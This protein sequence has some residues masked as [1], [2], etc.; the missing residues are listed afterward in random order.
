MDDEQLKRRAAALGPLMRAAGAVARAAL[1]SA[2]GLEL[3]DKGVADFVTA[4]DLAVQAQLY[5]ELAARFPEDAFF[6]EEGDE[7]AVDPARPTWVI[8]PID[9]TSNFAHGRP[10]WCVSAALV[11]GGRS[12]LAAVY[13]PLQDEL[14]EARRGGGA[15]LGERRLTCRRHDRIAGAQLVFGLTRKAPP[16]ATLAAVE[17]L[18]LEGGSFR[19]FGVGALM[20][21]YV[22]AGRIDGFFEAAIYAWDAAAA[23]LVAE[24]A[25]AV[26]SPR[27]RSAFDR[28][29]FP[30]LVA[31]P[32]LYPRLAA[33]LPFIAPERDVG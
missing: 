6:G 5:R 7:P 9:G 2:D 21:T 30:A 4:A 11:Q 14:F 31:T 1:N 27:A 18:A 17:R 12:R 33:E 3:R 10:G 28:A 24:E 22:G 26:V 16:G 23:T 19:S 25:G 29:P 8:D 13:D 15:W 20:I 32:A